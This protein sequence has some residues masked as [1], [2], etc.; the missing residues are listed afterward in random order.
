MSDPERAIAWIAPINYIPPPLSRPVGANRALTFH[1]PHY[2]TIEKTTP[3][4]IKAF[5]HVL[6][7]FCTTA[8][9]LSDFLCNLPDQ[10]RN[11]PVGPQNAPYF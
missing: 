6:F 9:V 1:S 5:S 8:V 4:M 2:D 10:K 7:I 11:A 3:G